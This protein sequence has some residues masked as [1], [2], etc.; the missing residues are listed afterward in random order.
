MYQLSALVCLLE[1]YFQF[2][3]QSYLIYLDSKF[4]IPC[5]VRHLIKQKEEGPIVTA[6]IEGPINIDIDRHCR[7]C[8]V[9]FV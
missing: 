5:I 6:C 4:W 9:I 7:H 3:F 8:G 1:L 2:K